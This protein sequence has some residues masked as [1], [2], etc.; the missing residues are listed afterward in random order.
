MRLIRK[1]PIVK[2]VSDE[3]LTQEEDIIS[4]LLDLKDT[5]QDIEILIIDPN[6]P[7]LTKKFDRARVLRVEDKKYDLRVFYKSA[8][9]RLRDLDIEGIKNLSFV[10]SKEMMSRKYSVSRWHLM[11]V[12]EIKLGE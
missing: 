11:D 12:A 7:G 3:D 5:N 2:T 9:T 1:E 10:A 4:L 8:T 6:K